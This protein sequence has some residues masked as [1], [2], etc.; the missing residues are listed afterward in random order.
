M[1]WFLA[2]EILA[3]A[4]G[5]GALGWIFG[6]KQ[7]EVSAYKEVAANEPAAA[8]LIKSIN[9]LILTIVIVAAIIFAV[10]YLSKK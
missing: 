5:A 6:K 9:S 1:V 10:K 7:G 3:A 8:K 4:G 2:P